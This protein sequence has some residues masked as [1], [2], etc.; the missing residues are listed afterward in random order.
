MDVITRLTRASSW[1]AAEVSLLDTE[2]LTLGE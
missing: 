2:A 1:A